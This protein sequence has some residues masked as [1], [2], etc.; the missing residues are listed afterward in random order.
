MLKM[1][2]HGSE[3]YS[4]SVLDNFMAGK[5]PY[6]ECFNK[7]LIENNLDTNEH[8]TMDKGGNDYMLELKSLITCD[9]T[10]RYIVHEDGFAEDRKGARIKG[11]NLTDHALTGIANYK[12][13]L[14]YYCDFCGPD[15]NLPSGRSVEDAL[16]YC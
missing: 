16:F 13:T 14:K 3:G 7:V 5:G 12:H 2:F 1:L 9:L 10:G 8:R 15:K 11:R 6:A 4:S